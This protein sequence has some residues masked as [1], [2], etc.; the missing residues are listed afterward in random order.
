MTGSRAAFLHA[1]RHPFVI[2]AAL[3]LGAALV[4]LGASAIFVWA[5]ARTEALA[6]EAGL[7]SVTSELRE[8]HFRARLA[9]DFAARQQQVGIL[10][11][12]LLQAKPEPEFIR[13]VETL[14]S[15]AGATATQFSSHSVQQIGGVNTTYFEFFLN[16]PYAGLR[17][18][19]AELPELN[20]FV[21]VDRVSFERNGQTVRAFLVLKRRQK[22]D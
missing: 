22:A 14:V 19:V 7:E 10:E 13:D 9:Q 20:E 17:Q 18:F 16:G 1:A 2:A 5:P 3:T 21:S 12:K 6:A 15:K 4:V 8:L 11:Q